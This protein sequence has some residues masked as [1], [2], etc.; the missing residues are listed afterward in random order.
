MKRKLHIG[1]LLAVLS[2]WAI[3]AFTSCSDD[4]GYWV[5]APPQGWNVYYDSRLNGDWQLIQANG[6]DVTGDATN[7]LEFF[8]DGVGRY[9]YY[10]NGRLYSERTNY[11]CNKAYSAGSNMQMNIKYESGQAATMLYWFTDNAN[12]LWMSWSTGSGTV[13][14]VYRYLQRIP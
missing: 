1:L 3:S 7:Y 14:Y 5:G 8:G 9:S 12:L 13:T 6:R 4:S 11:W 2:L 10:S